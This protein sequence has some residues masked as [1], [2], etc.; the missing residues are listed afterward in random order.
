LIATVVNSY[1]IALKRE[2]DSPDQLK[3]L[4]IP[5]LEHAP[6]MARVC[7]VSNL[8]ETLSKLADRLPGGE[9]EQLLPLLQ[10]VVSNLSVASSKLPPPPLADVIPDW[11]GLGV[12]NFEEIVGRA[13]VLVRLAPIYRL[14]G[15]DPTFARLFHWQYL[16]LLLRLSETLESVAVS[17]DS[18]C[19]EAISRERYL[20]TL[21]LL[22]TLLPLLKEIAKPSSASMQSEL[23]ELIVTFA[24]CA[25]RLS[26]WKG[27]DIPSNDRDRL[28]NKSISVIFHFGSSILGSMIR[29]ADIDPNGE[30]YKLARR[31]KTALESTILTSKNESMVRSLLQLFSQRNTDSD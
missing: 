12:S 22:K 20:S 26:I 4:L 8:E 14:D 7:K 18:D 16:G 30:D 17:G 24:E 9:S 13:L 1:L 27:S 3:R 2:V 5:L 15:P 19:F 25:Q 29:S 21:E 6:W 11:P 28:V 10:L 23:W 31:L